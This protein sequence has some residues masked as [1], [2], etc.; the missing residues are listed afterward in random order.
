LTVFAGG[1]YDST[2]ARGAPIPAPIAPGPSGQDPDLERLERAVVALAERH[3]EALREMA[4]LRETLEARERRIGELDE[5]VLELNQRR[6]DVAKR[7]DDLIAR[8]A[9]LEGQLEPARS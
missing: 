5:R 4:R 1:R 2:V 9:L 6:Q 7:I 8:I 3:R